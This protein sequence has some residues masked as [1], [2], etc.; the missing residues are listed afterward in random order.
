MFYL[1]LCLFVMPFNLSLYPPDCLL[2]WKLDVKVWLDS[3][4]R[5]LGVRIL[6]RWDYIIHILSHQTS[7]NVWSLDLG[8]KCN[9]CPSV[10]HPLSSFHPV[11]PGFAELYL[12]PLEMTLCATTALKVWRWVMWAIPFKSNSIYW[13]F[14]YSFKTETPWNQ[15]V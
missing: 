7:H 5:F 9:P 1:S 12:N 2:K 6:H 15:N 11:V 13:Y 14:D 3:V 8:G 10:M 4:S